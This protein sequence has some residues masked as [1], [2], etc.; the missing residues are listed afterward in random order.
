MLDGIEVVFFYVN[1]SGDDELAR[2]MVDSV[3]EHM[4]G[5]PITQL[6]DMITD[7]VPGVDMVVR[8]EPEPGIMYFRSCHMA[9]YRHRAAIFLDHDIVVLKDLRPVFDE[10]F[11]V[12]LTRRTRKELFIDEVPDLI[13]PNENAA[14]RM[15]YNMGVIFSRS[16]K[17]WAD[18]R[19]L[20]AQTGEM[21]REWYGEQIALAN[22]LGSGRFKVKVLSEDYNYSPSMPLEDVSERAVLHFKGP[23]RKQWMM[24]RYKTCVRSMGALKNVDNHARSTSYRCS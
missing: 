19:N 4:P 15:P 3:R 1:R 2:I 23:V 17:L 13:D 16:T 21:G 6:T 20:H 5:V 11:D 18:H 10:P 12:A 7:D 8:R 9:E 14:E 22:V 24:Q